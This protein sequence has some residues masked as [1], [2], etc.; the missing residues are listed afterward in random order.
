M[1]HS[2]DTAARRRQLGVTLAEAVDNARRFASAGTCGH[3]LVTGKSCP[4]H[5]R[6]AEVHATLD[7]VDALAAVV[8]RPA[9]DGTERI[10][11]DAN[12]H[13]ISRA[14]VAYALREAAD[15]FDTAARGEG[16]EPIPHRS[17]VESLPHDALLDEQARQLAAAITELGKARGWS[18]WAADYIHPDREFVDPGAPDP[19]EHQ[20]AEEQPA[21]GWVAEVR[22][23]LAFN[24]RATSHPAVITLRDVLLDTAP[25]TSEQALD[26]ACILLAAHTREL[27][28][29]AGQHTDDYRAEHG[30]SRSS[31]G[32]LTG[33]ASIRRLL[34]TAARRLD[35][36]AQQ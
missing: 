23:A 17:A 19:D 26:A 24:A 3:N 11:V 21:A 7:G 6:P 32:L 36:K 10:T 35:P 33:M 16:D 20:A 13:G 28:T 4:K 9:N 29:A 1:S 12:A 18:V 30:V 15:A 8:I 5:S 22:Q 31:R 25:R 14:A 34:D 27:A 2:S